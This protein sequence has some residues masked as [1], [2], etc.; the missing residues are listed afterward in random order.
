MA[1]ALIN[2]R[3]FAHKDIVFNVGGVPVTSL[4]NLDVTDNQNKEFSY[5][6]GGLPVG[7]GVG[8]EEQKDVSF[9]ISHTDF[10]ALTRA[11]DDNN[12]KSLDPFDIPVTLLNASNP[13]S[14]V[15]KNFCVTED[16]F[17]SD[18][19][20]TDIKHTVTGIASHIVWTR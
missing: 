5:G 1:V 4:S 19:D 17:S 2:G 15:I 7:I 12:I 18:I 8:R 13:S 16:S 20:T 10:I 3:N 14:F 11:T 9:E 6:T